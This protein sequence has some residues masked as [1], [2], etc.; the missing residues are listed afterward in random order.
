MIRVFEHPD[1][2]EWTGT[3][4][5]RATEGAVTHSY[6]CNLR[7]GGIRIPRAD[8]I[9]A[10]ARTMGFAPQLWFKDAAWWESLYERWKNGEDVSEEFSAGESGAE[11]PHA[12]GSAEGLA[13]RV[14]ALMRG[15]G[16]DGPAT[17]EEVARLGGR[18]LTAADVREVLDGTLADPSWSQVLALCSAF[19][20]PPGYLFGTPG[21]WRPSPAL[22]RAA[23]DPDSYVI[24]QNSL[25]LSRSD[26]VM[27]RNLSEHLRRGGHRPT[28]GPTGGPTDGPDVGDSPQDHPRSGA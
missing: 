28:G 5:E 22:V 19:G 17:P 20:V 14:A 21:A 26:R 15:A 8:K 11:R 6:Y 18:P 1:G 13:G 16:P 2:G 3:R 23:A 12:A 9:D 4:M 7:D 10:I 25:E 24:F 27:L